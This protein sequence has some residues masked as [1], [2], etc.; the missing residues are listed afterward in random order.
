LFEETPKKE[1][2][3]LRF[4]PVETEGELVKVGL[5]MIRLYGPLMGSEQPSLEEAG[6]AVNPRQ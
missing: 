3:E 6:D 5:K 4:A 2:S 1:P